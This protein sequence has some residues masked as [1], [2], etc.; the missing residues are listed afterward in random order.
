MW[1]TAPAA[2]QSF[3][4]AYRFRTLSTAH[5]RIHF[6]QGEDQ[7]AARLAVIAER[8]WQAMKHALGRTPPPLTD[9]VLVD[10]ADL[11]NGYATPLPRNTVVIHAVWPAGSSFLKT[12]DWLELCFTHE[13]THI[14]HLDR[15]EG[16]ARVVRGVFGRPLIAFPNLFL[17]QWQIEGLATYEESLMTGTGRLQAGNFRAI[18]GEAARAR[19]P[20]PIDRVNGGLT[21]W[22]GG[23]AAYA[24]GLAFHAYLADRY[25]TETLAALSDATARRFPFFAYRAFPLVYGKS[26]SALWREFEQTVPTASTAGV[27]ANDA[28]RLT[29][30]GFVVAGPRFVPPRCA[31]SATFTSCAEELWYSASDAHRLPALHRIRTDGSEPDRVATRYLGS[32]IGPGR[33]TIYFTQQD[34]RRNT[35]M[36]GDLYALDRATGHIRR[37][38]TDARLGDLDL[39]PDAQTIAAVRN[40]P[41]QRD[42]VLIARESRGMSASA[43]VDGMTTLLAEPETQFNAPRWSPDGRSVAVER[44][45]RGALSEIAIVDVATRA[46]RVVASN[47]DVRW[48]TP[49]WRPDGR[50]I[51]AAA[52]FKEGRDGPFNLHE[53]DLVTA[54]VRQL[55]HAAGG[56]IWP[57][58]SPDG[59]TIV[60]VG[61]TTDGFDV[62]RIAYPAAGAP[63][64]ALDGDV[65]GPV[66]PDARE[67]TAPVSRGTM[68]SA[69]VATVADVSGVVPYRPWSTLPPTS[70]W[71]LVES[72]RQQLRLGAATGGFDVLGYHA[73][74]FSA[75]WGVS[76]PSGAR[77]A[78]GGAPDWNVVYAYTRWRPGFWATAARETSFVAIRPTDSGAP[79]ASAF[80]ERRVELGIRVPVNRVR[81]SHGVLASVVRADDDVGAA[82]RPRAAAR[83]GWWFTSAHQ[84]GYSV[85]AERGVAIGATVEV[86]RRAFGSSAD[87][88]TVAGDARAYVP[89]LAEHHVL[90]IRA[91]GGSTTG[92]HQTGRVFLLGGAESNISLVNFGS[93]AMSLLR[94]FPSNTFAGTHVALAN[95]DY[96]FPIA[97]P[98]RG[99]GVWPLFLHTIHATLFADAGH[100]WT[101]TFSAR[102]LKASFGAEFSASVVAGYVLPI[103]VTVGGAWG[104]D[105]SRQVPSGA[106]W[107]ARV[108][109]A[110]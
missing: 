58:V 56:A 71:P 101:E 81:E 108:G 73:Y 59:K 39:S 84:Y 72:P 5:F 65:T 92:D 46:V 83:A 66:E 63:D 110:F 57:D 94:G 27:A 67:D 100:V 1:L 34:L 87:A 106:R 88:T 33:E 77:N 23:Q 97:R 76:R 79:S 24:Y 54:Q 19:T 95:A 47:A 85:S 80:H 9:V 37:L 31:A 53:I 69:P 60:Y 40:R 51:V 21:D 50:T 20:E 62:F 70:W 55:T 104:H 25:G 82:S 8:T 48:V 11:P 15:S 38:T 99:L 49:A 35:A 90:A 28:E 10:Q 78:G 86:V 91:S 74:A 105:G 52:D 107:Y 102:N 4:P 41:G 2:A 93:N 43:G 14:V 89:G 12:D 98:Q 3:D 75:T 64:V 30:Q 29:H 68:A 16:W 6:H 22:P 61:Y 36:Y 109:Y 96:R 44:Q 18:V 13:F 32:T 26:L 103:A 45:R 7:L 17:P 42:L